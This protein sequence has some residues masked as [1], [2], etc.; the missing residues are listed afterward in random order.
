MIL[1]LLLALTTGSAFASQESASEMAKCPFDSQCAVLPASVAPEPGVRARA[2]Q[3]STPTPAAQAK[4]NPK[5]ETVLTDEAS[6]IQ[7]A[8]I[9]IEEQVRRKFSPG[10]QPAT[11][12]AHAKAHGCVKA[13]FTALSDEELEEMVED[14]LP[15]DLRV[16]VFKKGSSYPAWIRFSNSGGDNQ[17]DSAGDNRGMAVKLMGV[18]GEKLLENDERA[19]QDFL[20]ASSPSAFFKDVK[21]YAELQ[22]L[23]T[24]YD[25]NRTSIALRYFGLSML[26]GN[27]R[28]RELANMIGKSF[29]KMASPIDIRYWSV[30]PSQLGPNQAVKYSAVPCSGVKKAKLTG[31]E[32]PD[33]LREAMRSTL[34]AHDACYYLMVQLQIAP[35]K[36]PIDDASITWDEEAAPFRK[37]AK[38]HIFAQNFDTPEQNDFCENLSF[39]PWH[40]IVEHKPLGG[41]NRARL[42]VYT[43]ISKLRHRLNATPRHEPTA[44]ASWQP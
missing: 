28:W 35:D 3:P 32:P 9:A 29:Q 34:A 6:D 7:R 20:L 13:R 40:S 26:N 30:L 17:K 33:H 5:L 4:A 21:A 10:K 31:Q 18:P 44:D 39:S 36:M 24:K 22:E 25:G 43:A 42:A 11:R 8:I 37:V 12:D 23:N 15:E 14:K 38:I 16:G 27:F 2:H 1:H 41:L 19:T